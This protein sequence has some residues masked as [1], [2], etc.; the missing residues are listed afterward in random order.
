[1]LPSNRS[2]HWIVGNSPT[3]ALSSAIRRRAD[4]LNICISPID[5]GIPSFRFKELPVSLH[6]VFCHILQT[7]FILS[8]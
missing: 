1:M 7:G 4:V 8:F 6:R 2:F 5:R 3:E